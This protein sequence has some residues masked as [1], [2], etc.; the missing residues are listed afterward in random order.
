MF[1]IQFKFSRF[2][3]CFWDSVS[4][5]CVVFSFSEVGCSFRQ[6]FFGLL[7]LGVSNIVLLSCSLFIFWSISSIS[8]SE[9][10]TFFLLYCLDRQVFDL[11][12]EKYH[13]LVS[14]LSFF[15]YILFELCY[16]LNSGLV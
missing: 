3:F 16:S 1:I 10:Q 14:S 8:K 7:I 5:G 9:N 13:I 4:S 12:S 11:L 15:S 6:A 2:T